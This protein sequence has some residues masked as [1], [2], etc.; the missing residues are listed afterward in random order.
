MPDEPDEIDEIEERL[1][2][3]AAA[4]D[5]RTRVLLAVCAPFV[6]R[7]R[8]RFDEGS[9]VPTVAGELGAPVATIS[10]LFIVHVRWKHYEKRPT[11]SGVKAS[12]VF[13]RIQ[14]GRSVD[15]IAYE[16]GLARADVEELR[17]DYDRLAALEPFVPD[18]EHPHRFGDVYH[19][20]SDRKQEGATHVLLV[21]QLGSFVG[22]ERRIAFHGD[23]QHDGDVLNGTRLV[24][25]LAKKL[26][27]RWWLEA[28]AQRV[29][30]PSH[31]VMLFEP[32]P[33]HGQN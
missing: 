25:Q 8:Q 18:T 22:C 9:D 2:E 20:L 29:E 32:A 30:S 19:W 17:A 12:L 13:E 14:S 10:D 3:E 11:L 5:E 28:Y 15:E 6:E 4:D 7:A 16:L 26:P 1:A 31:T 23:A 27:G 21:R 33:P 24:M